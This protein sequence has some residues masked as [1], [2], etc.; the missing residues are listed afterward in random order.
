MVSTARRYPPLPRSQACSERA[1]ANE[2]ARHLGGPAAKDYQTLYYKFPLAMKR[3]T[4]VT[5]CRA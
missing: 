3:A 2:A 4:P 1:R 5:R